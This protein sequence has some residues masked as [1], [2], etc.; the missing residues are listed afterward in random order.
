M[1]DVRDVPRDVGGI[2]LCKGCGNRKV[3]DDDRWICPGC[4]ECP[5]CGA[6]HAD[7]DGAAECI[8]VLHDAADE[9][10]ADAREL[11]KHA[12]KLEKRAARQVEEGAS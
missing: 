3:R 7:T 12:R 1:S 2:E 9:A 8:D 4:D 11:R 10:A 6:V 5:E